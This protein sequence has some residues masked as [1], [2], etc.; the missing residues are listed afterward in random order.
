MKKITNY[1]ILK[2]EAKKMQ[3][4]TCFQRGDQSSFFPNFIFQHVSVNKN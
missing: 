4:W 2:N 3:K 1:L